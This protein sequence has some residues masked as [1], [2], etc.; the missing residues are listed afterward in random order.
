MDSLQVFAALLQ[1][2]SEE[3]KRGRERSRKSRR[4]RRR[5]RRKRVGVEIEREAAGRE[6]RGK[7]K[8]NLGELTVIQ[9]LAKPPLPFDC[10]APAVLRRE[11]A[12]RRKGKERKKND[13]EGN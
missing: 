10:G 1:L 2:G 13:G 12:R 4:R 9:N 11:R 8:V 6:P 5:R 7:G 3:R